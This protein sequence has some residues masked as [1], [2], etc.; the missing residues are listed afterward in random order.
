MIRSIRK[1]L[2]VNLLISIILS[3]T[4]AALGNYILDQKDIQD[5][6]DSLLTQSG[7][8]FQ[9]LI[10]DN[11]KPEHLFQI[12]SQLNT[13]PKLAEKFYKT[14]PHGPFPYIYDNKFQF[15]VWDQKGKLMI[16]SA[17]APLTP[18]SSLNAGFSNISLQ[19]HPWR[20]FTLPASHKNFIIMVAQ[21]YDARAD[22]GHRIARDDLYILLIVY[23]LL[24]F[25]IWLIVGR[26]LHPLRKITDEVS[27]RIP[28]YLEPMDLRYVPVEITPLMDELNHLLL[29]LKHALEREKRFAG[30]AAHELKTPLAALKTQAEVALRA[31][32]EEERTRALKNLISTVDRSSH[33]V[34]QLLTLSRLI[35]EEV[36]YPMQD[37]TSVNLHRLAMEEIAQCASE[38]FS[39]NIELE[40]NCSDPS[41]TVDGNVTALGILLRNLLDNAIR[42]S[43][44]NTLVTVKIKKMEEKVIL[45]VSDEGPGIPEELRAR[46]FE[47]FYRIL[48]T[49]Q[50]GSGLGLAIVQQI[51]LFHQAEV[52]LNTPSSGK[53]LEVQIIFPA[54]NNSRRHPTDVRS[55][56][57][58]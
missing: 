38:P 18:L 11:L 8:A 47:R 50:P 17:Q 43:P 1:F 10:G 37:I 13:I 26:G 55:L 31:T 19:N 36:A 35:P 58:H 20:V 25:L 57:T 48:G 14:L 12:Q 44:S 3:T 23:L 45:S 4:I 32:H 21:R 41:I 51:A 30:D 39:Q 9:A 16:R 15:Q 33:I 6:L 29:R 56:H 34:S 2:L 7:F 53:G 5:H 42:Y 24:G 40:L 27:H 22:L 28:T 49:Q 52:R 54:H 46:V